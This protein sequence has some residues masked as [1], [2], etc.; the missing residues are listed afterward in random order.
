MAQHLGLFH[1]FLSS[2]L[3]ERSIL[4]TQEG[5]LLH[6]RSAKV[7]DGASLLTAAQTVRLYFPFEIGDVVLLN[8]PYSG[9]TTLEEYTLI[10]ALPWLDEKIF[11]A[12]RFSYG[13]ITNC[14]AQKLDEEGLRIPPTPIAQKG[15]INS[16]ILQA[17]GSHPHCATGLC[18]VIETE[19]K[20]LLLVLKNWQRTIACKPSW[21]NK[22][23][24]KEYI[25]ETQRLAQ[26]LVN[27]R[28]SGETQVELRLDDGELLKLKLEI[29]DG[30]ATFDFSGTNNSQ[31]LFLTESAVLSVCHEVL[32]RFYHWPACSHGTLGLIRVSTPQGSW[33]QAKSPSPTAKGFATGIPALMTAIDLALCHIHANEAEKFR[34]HNFLRFALK[35]DEQIRVLTLPG[36]CQH[37]EICESISVEQLEQNHPVLV[38]RISLRH[39]TH[40]EGLMMQV[41]ALKDLTLGWASNLTKH[42]MKSPKN[43]PHHVPPEVLIDGIQVESV[44]CRDLS[45]GQTILIKS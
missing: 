30:H 45:S 4:V 6:S 22:T 16:M 17:M 42:K 7:Y 37:Q 24:L 8:D 15:Q 12:H 13:R 29:S 41:K 43:S 25:Q 5:Q 3:P 1:Q 35:S 33:L 36:S 38:E 9:G 26:D 39:T 31:G 18:Q 10:T 23:S 27:D 14:Q 20:K 34:P 21:L 40:H 11:L 19:T 2:T 28:A 44:G 32:A